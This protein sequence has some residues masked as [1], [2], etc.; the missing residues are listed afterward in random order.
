MKK[1]ARVYQFHPARVP[2]VN[3]Q[4]LMEVHSRWTQR[5]GD[6][7]TYGDCVRSAWLESRSLAGIVCLE[8]DV[9]VSRESWLELGAA[10]KAW[11]LEVI[12]VPY[13]LYPRSTG[14]GT[15]A[16]AH[17]V[18]AFDGRYEFLPSTK[19]CPSAPAAFGL[20]CTFLPGRLLEAM[21][22]D[23]GQWDYPTLDTKLSDLARELG[24]AVRCTSLPAI[25]L[26]Y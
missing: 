19:A 24:V 6:G 22:E 26:H 11:P 16:W 20:G 25:H 23:L 12:A 18:S 2:V 9:A 21:P 1:L 3:Y 13:L 5:Q 4:G 14:R 8:H 17:R 10:I 7:P 15:A